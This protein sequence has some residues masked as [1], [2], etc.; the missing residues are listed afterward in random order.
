MSEKK[1]IAWD[2]AKLE[3]MGGGA[4]AMIPQ[5]NQQA[6]VPTWRECMVFGT[7]YSLEEIFRNHQDAWNRA[8]KQRFKYVAKY[9][10]T[11][12]DDLWNLIKALI[13]VYQV[14]HPPMYDPNFGVAATEAAEI[15]ADSDD[16][17]FQA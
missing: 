5:K 9:S 7:N 1:L 16:E 3:A 17:F 4:L 8:L 11:D 15:P 10:G 12:G 14:P 2:P 13:D 6:P